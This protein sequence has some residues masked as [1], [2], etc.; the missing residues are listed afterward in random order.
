MVHNTRGIVLRT[1]K[2]GETSV[3]ATIFT[4]LFGIQSYLINGVRV[5][6]PKGPRNATLLQP[7]AIL[8]LVV[9]SNPLRNLQRVKEFRWGYLYRHIFFDV[10]KNS[11]SLFMVELLHKCLKQPEPNDELFNFIEDIFIHLDESELV[12]VANYPLFFAINLAHFFGFKIQD[13]YSERKTILDLQQGFFTDEYPAHNAYLDGEFSAI[14]S[15]LLKVRQPG[16]LSQIRLN[17][18]VRRVLLAAYMSYYAF[19][20]QDFGTMR[21]IAVLQAIM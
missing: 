16:E 17:Q 13:G 19:H 15:Q 6:S 2:Y 20:V 21:T 3:V 12:I 11:V 7:G 4:H 9:Y 1:V 10:I 5:S 18:D 8:D 14:T